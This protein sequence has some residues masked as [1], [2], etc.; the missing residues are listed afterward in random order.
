MARILEY[1]QRYNTEYY[2]YW[3]MQSKR[4]CTE[5]EINGRWLTLE[6]CWEC[7]GHRTLVDLKIVRKYEHDGVIYKVEETKPGKYKITKI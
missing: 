1:D 2:E 7:P 6:E 4:Y 3:A 5:G